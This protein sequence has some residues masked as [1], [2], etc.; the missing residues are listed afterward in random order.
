MTDSLC[1]KRTTS[2]SASPLKRIRKPLS[3]PRFVFRLLLQSHQKLKCIL[4]PRFLLAA[5]FI[6]GT[7]QQATEVWNIMVQTFPEFIASAPTGRFSGPG[8]YIS[9]RHTCKKHQALADYKLTEEELS[10]VDYCEERTGHRWWRGRPV[11]RYYRAYDIVAVRELSM[12]KHG[13]SE[14]KR[15]RFKK[16]NFQNRKRELR[17]Q[18]QHVVR[19]ILVDLGLTEEHWIRYLC[20]EMC[21]D[22]LSNGKNKTE[23]KTTLQKCVTILDCEEVKKQDRKVIDHVIAEVTN[24]YRISEI[25]DDVVVG[26]IRRYQWI[27]Q[28]ATSNYP[29]VLA[30]EAQF[31]EGEVAV[32]DITQI[33]KNHQDVERQRVEQNKREKQRRRDE[34][35]EALAVKDLQQSEQHDLLR[36]HACQ[37]Y[38]E[39]GSGSAATIVEE[40][41]TKYMEDSEATRQQ[42]RRERFFQRETDYQK[43]RGKF[44]HLNAQAL[45]LLKKIYESGVD[46]LP[47]NMLVEFLNSWIRE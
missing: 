10:V 24:S 9:R 33:I 20:D 28:F 18:R 26:S 40:L 6:F 19:N 8:D 27:H 47:P 34:L 30:L 16:E 15:F 14:Y 46:D 38:I 37:N 23:L 17:Q 12:W 2:Q 35:T 13:L 39:L 43:L 44:G 32:E 41:Y 42:K 31:M 45:A 7:P 4:R 11:R 3:N 22:F 1:S 29:D 5:H 36:M 21:E 25:D